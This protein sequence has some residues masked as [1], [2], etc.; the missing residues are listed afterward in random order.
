VHMR[1]L[2]IQ[3]RGSTSMCAAQAYTCK[4]ACYNGQQTGQISIALYSTTTHTLLH[5]RRW[6]GCASLRFRCFG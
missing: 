4:R 2:H 5:H 1:Q 6:R 3:F